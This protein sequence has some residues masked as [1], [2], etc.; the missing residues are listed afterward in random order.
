M[1]RFFI[2]RPVDK[3]ETSIVLDGEDGRHIERSLR[4]SLGEEIAVCDSL[5]NEH[6]CKIINIQ[7]GV[8][9]AEILY[10]QPCKNEP[11][12]KVT[13]YQ[14]LTKGDKMDMIIQKA[15]E[16]GVTGIVPVLTKRCV[17]RPDEKSLAKKCLRWQKI[18]QQAAMQSHRGIIPVVE[19]P[20]DFKK[21]IEKSRENQKNILFYEKGGEKLS[22]CGLKNVK[23]LGVF[24]GSEGGFDP[25]EVSDFL[26]YGGNTATLGKRILRAET[27]PLAALAV[28]MYETG[29]MD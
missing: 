16:L 21:A 8:V 17:S 26:E 1:P 15:V 13:L 28:I 4:M 14:A 29:N 18:A 24:I 25:E 5:E 20:V 3:D 10:S 23:N 2:D 12:V 6:Y 11:S 9:T 27:A 22:D 7:N 19:K